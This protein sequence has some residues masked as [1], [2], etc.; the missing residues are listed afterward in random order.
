MAHALDC[1]FL[2]SSRLL[3]SNPWCWASPER[4]SRVIVDR[5]RP[6]RSSRAERMHPANGWIPRTRPPT[7]RS[8]NTHPSGRLEPVT[9]TGAAPRPWFAIGWFA[10]WG[11]L[12]GFIVASVLVGTWERPPAFP[13]EA[14][15]ALIYP[16]MFFIPLYFLTA[17]LLYREHTLGSVF[18]FVSG[19]GV[20]YAMLYLVALS[21][22]SGTGNLVADGIFLACTVAALWQVHR[23]SRAHRG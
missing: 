13:Q 19:G 3:L 5:L 1:R 20:I 18:A 17:A 2:L 16:D 7:G 12:Q 4:P 22:F 9:S 15:E 6:G 10:I 23:T 14:Y 21:G 8:T 11:L